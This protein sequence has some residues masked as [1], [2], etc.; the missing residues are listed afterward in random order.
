MKVLHYYPSNTQTNSLETYLRLLSEN[1]VE[2]IVL[3]TCERGDFHKNVEAFGIP[4]YTF[5]Y[6]SK[7]RIG[8]YWKQIRFLRNFVKTHQIDHVFSHLQQANFIAVLAARFHKKPTTLFRHHLTIP[9][10]EK[11]SKM[12][13]F[14]DRVIDR[15]G[16]QIVV[17][18]PSVLQNIQKYESIRKEK[19]QVI[20]Y[21]YDFDKYPKPDSERVQQI[22][23]NYKSDFI[24][25]MCSRFVASK[26]H[27]YALD[28]LGILIRDYQWNIQLLL[29]DHGPL[30]EEVKM[31]ISRKKLE[32]QVEIV[33]FTKEFVNYMAA[34]DLLFH[35]S[36]TETSSSTVKEMGLLGK[37]VV[38]TSGVGD[39]DDYIFS[40][41]NGWKMELDQTPEETA[42][43][44]D[45]ILKDAESLKKNGESLKE[46]VQS[47][48]GLTSF[49]LNAYLALLNQAHERA[50]S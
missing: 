1:G 41:E 20:P 6:Q 47:T 19:Y 25:L 15:F 8:Y 42:K 26:R 22:R 31:E 16:K 37:P 12:E 2:L 35:P 13:K 24:F 38:V 32:K 5:E 17:A 39:F 18:S 10:V 34:A 3:T 29:L 48:F 27:Y 44:L 43:L 40:G 46:T 11:V 50:N 14:F 28:V 7:T 30:L 23:S 21:C 49:H 33:G 45:R 36:L 9:G 4:C